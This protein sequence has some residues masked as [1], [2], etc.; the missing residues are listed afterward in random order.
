MRSYKTLRG[1]SFGEFTV[2]RSRF[3]CYGAQVNSKEEAEVFIGSVKTNHWDAKHNVYAYTVADGN[4]RKFSD[5]G[6]PQGTA[7]MP[8]LSVIEALELQDVAIVVT[9]YFGGV[10]LGTGG[11][12]RAYSY[13][14]R[15][16]IDSCG[17]VE[18]CELTAV[19]VH[20][21]Y[22]DFGK[23]RNSIMNMGAVIED[24]IYGDDVKLIFYILPEK[25]PQVCALASELSQGRAVAKVLG[26]EKFFPREA[27]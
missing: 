27:D 11:L 13:G 9:R 1:R 22:T 4:V 2:K 20:L 17:I 12:A 25:L 23:F 21:G 7:G 8:V 19:E 6:E 3:I 18:M 16:A 24:C 14:A 15:V 10:L 5:D 26:R